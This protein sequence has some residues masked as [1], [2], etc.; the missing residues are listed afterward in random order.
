[1]KP[2][3]VPIVSRLVVTDDTHASVVLHLV[4]GS[5]YAMFVGLDAPLLAQQYSDWVSTAEEAA[6]SQE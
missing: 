5:C 4:T 1:M 2:V 6:C 3:R